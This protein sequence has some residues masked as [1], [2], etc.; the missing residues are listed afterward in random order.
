[1]RH[2]QAVA[3][4]ETAGLISSDG[5]LPADYDF[6]HVAAGVAV[7]AAVAASDALCCL[8]LGE[9]ARGQYHGE[10]V[11]LLAEMTERA[12]EDIEEWVQ[13]VR[14]IEW[15]DQFAMTP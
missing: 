12:E 15:F 14:L 10:A 6:N 13:H 11:D 4:L 2:R 3:Y 8:L 7:L 9:R 1:M 5:S